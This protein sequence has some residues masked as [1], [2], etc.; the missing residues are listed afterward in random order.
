MRWELGTWNYWSES[1]ICKAMGHRVNKRGAR[2]VNIGAMALYVNMEVE[3]PLDDSGNRLHTAST[4][5]G[6]FMKN[7]AAKKRS[8]QHLTKTNEYINGNGKGILM[9][10][11]ALSTAYQNMKSPCPN[12]RNEIFTD[13]EIHNCHI[14]PSLQCR[15]IKEI[16]SFLIACPPTGPSI[17]EFAQIDL[18]FFFSPVRVRVNAI[19][20]FHMYILTW[21]EDKHSYFLETC[22]VDKVVADIEKAVIE[23]LDKQFADVVALLK[24]KF[25]GFKYIQRLTKPTTRYL[26]PPKGSCCIPDGRNVA[27]GERLSYVAV[28]LRSKIKD[29]IQVICVKLSK[30]EYWD[31]MGQNVL[32]FLED[33]KEIAHGIKVQQ[34][35]FLNG[36]FIKKGHK[37]KSTKAQ[38]DLTTRTLP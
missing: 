31:E 13:I 12:I 15:P 21:I 28:M 1:L 36:K 16:T 25:F 19:E 34:L 30:I 3:L 26:V 32:R 20:L 2:S 10:P 17:H 4:A 27:A 24:E 37:G 5:A 6:V 14:L 35:L 23:A 8:R 7:V 38:R 9:D 33:R 18:N 29:Y 22:D 11:T